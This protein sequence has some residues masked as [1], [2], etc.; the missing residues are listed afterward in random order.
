MKHPDRGELGFWMCTALVVG[1]TIG[2]GIFLLP[3]GLAPYGLNA[4]AGWVAVVLGCI[5]V[6]RVFVRLARSYPEAGGPYGYLREELGEGTAFF[7]IWCYWISLWV[8]NAALATGVVGYLGKLVPPLAAL[9]SAAVALALLWLFVL[10]NLLGARTGGGVQVVTTALKL[11]PMVAVM[12]LGLWWLFTEPGVYTRAV[13]ETPL[14]LGATTAAAATALYAMLGFES[15]TVPA[16][17]VKDPARTIPRATI[18][19][20]VLVAVVYIA[21]S[22]IPILLIPQA[23]LAASQAPFV[24]VLNRFLGGDSGRLLAFFVVVSGIGALNGWTL[25]VGELTRTMAVSGVLPASLGGVNGRGAP[26]AALLGTGLLAAAMIAMTF[27]RTLV[28][29]FVFL[30]NVVTA[31]T[32]PLY[33]FCSLALLRLWRRKRGEASLELPII[34]LLGIA[35]AV[36]AFRGMGAEASLWALV[37]AAAGVPLYAWMRW[38]RGRGPHHG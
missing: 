7:V 28:D 21:V 24:D 16:G 25:L 6:A 26:V 32:L 5:A 37:F 13:P 30:T 14:S 15:A 4:L 3:A 29:S 18:A 23:E 20:T 12:V 19:G 31:A 33:L 38:Q 36:F 11:L 35:F 2:M 10:V 1:N 17:K 9:P 27:S 22:A 34:G 8:T